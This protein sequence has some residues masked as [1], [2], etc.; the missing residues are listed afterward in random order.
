MGYDSFGLPTE[1]YA[2]ETGIHPELATKNNISRYRK[3]LDKLGFSYDWSREIR[4]SDKIIIDGHNGS[5]NNFI[6]HIIV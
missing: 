4:T 3:Q 2:I 6:I 1:Q 5:S